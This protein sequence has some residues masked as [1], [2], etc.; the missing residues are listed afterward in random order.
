MHPAN[1]DPKIHNPNLSRTAGRKLLEER[2]LTFGELGKK[3]QEQWPDH[4]PAA[5]AQVVRAYAALVQ[6]PPRGLWGRSGLAVHTTAEHWLSRPLAREAAPDALILRYLAAFGPAGIADARTWSG[7][8]G[9][10]RTRFLDTVLVD[11][12]VRG[13]WSVEASRDSATLIVRSLGPLAGKDTDALTE[14]GLRLLAFL[15]AGA[16]RHD[17]QFTATG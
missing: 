14:E 3:L 10:D 13:S 9:H 7:L 6:V 8:T 12:A 4:D 1:D 11:G 2:P 5:L 16:T 17:V 15:A